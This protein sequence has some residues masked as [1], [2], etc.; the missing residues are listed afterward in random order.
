MR[1]MWKLLLRKRAVTPVISS[2]ILT[3]A[4]V[5]VS[6]VVLSWAQYRSS[7]YNE[8]YGD[9]MDADIAK[10]KETLTFEYVFYDNDTKKLQVYLMNCGTIDN[11]TIQTVYIKDTTGAL[12]QV[13]SS[14]P[15][16]NFNGDQIVDDLDIGKECKFILS[17][18]LVPDTYSV[19][20]VTG[21]GSTFDHA[22][23]A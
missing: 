17:L 9:V 8:Q 19:R 6:F 21:R 4:V 13:N 12:I 14:I 2:V 22:F 3:G 5:A 7:A 18:I 1:K 20:V 16:T 10:L 23:I 11:V 15:L